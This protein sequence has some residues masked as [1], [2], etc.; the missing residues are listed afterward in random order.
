[1]GL[2]TAVYYVVMRQVHQLVPLVLAMLTLQQAACAQQVPR[3][4]HLK[5]LNQISRLQNRPSKSSKQV[6]LLTLY[7]KENLS[8]QQKADLHF[9]RGVIFQQEGWL[10]RARSDF[11]RAMLAAP[12][13][14]YQKALDNI[15]ALCERLAK[16]I[17]TALTSAVAPHWSGEIGPRDVIIE[18]SSDQRRTKSIVQTSGANSADESALQA[19]QK[20]NLPT[21]PSKSGLVILGASTAARYGIATTVCPAD[22]G[23]VEN[24]DE[25]KESFRQWQRLYPGL[26]YPW[27]SPKAPGIPMPPY[28]TGLDR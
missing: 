9:Q 10:D 26:K 24:A 28:G 3:Q 25:Q 11:Q 5:L 21:I 6:E 2:T 19:V 7:L 20:A 8:E 27:E 18:V 15:E 23:F 4:N 14:K 16:E 13:P 22:Q 1:M 12:Q 17:S